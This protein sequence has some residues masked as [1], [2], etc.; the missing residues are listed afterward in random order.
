MACSKEMTPF[1]GM[2]HLRDIGLQRANNHAI[3]TWAAAKGYTILTTDND[4]LKMSQQLG[5]QP[6]V[7]HI[8]GATSISSY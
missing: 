3:W 8:E 6:K 5:W 4:F 1:P 2:I 7:I